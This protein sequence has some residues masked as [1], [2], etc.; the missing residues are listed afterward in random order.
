[1]TAYRDEL[2][3]AK[4]RIAALQDQL[5]DCQG[6]VALSAREL[7]LRDERLERLCV[8]LERV[9]AQRAI[10][11]ERGLA[12][13]LLAATLALFALVGAA[14]LWTDN[15]VAAQRIEQLER[16][17]TT[18]EAER[19]ASADGAATT[20]RPSAVRLAQHV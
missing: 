6:R 12:G 8:G 2:G 17:I 20:Q 16:E 5:V 4:L 9:G 1:M 14:E 11:R 18:L 7:R 13:W 15:A 19:A 10:E 3:A